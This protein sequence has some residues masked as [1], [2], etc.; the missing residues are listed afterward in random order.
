MAK[1]IKQKTKASI[2]PKSLI[3]VGVASL[4]SA[5]GLGIY[6]AARKKPQEVKSSSMDKSPS[7]DQTQ[8][9]PSSRR[10]QN[11]NR[12]VSQPSAIPVS[13]RPQDSQGSKAQIQPAVF[14]PA[15]TAS[16]TPDTQSQRAP[17][18]LPAGNRTIGSTVFY[19][20]EKNENPGTYTFTENLKGSPL[21]VTFRA[22]PRRGLATN[23]AENAKYIG[24]LMGVSGA[25]KPSDAEVDALAYMILRER[26]AIGRLSS[27]VEAQRE[28]VAML[29]AVVNRVYS[30]KRTIVGVLCRSDMV[31]Y[32]EDFKDPSKCQSHH[33][34][35]PE[36]RAAFKDL[37]RGFFEGN[38][39]CE[40]EGLQNW[41]HPSG[42]KNW[43]SWYLP[44]GTRDA[45][46]SEISKTSTIEP[47]A[48]EDAVFSR[49]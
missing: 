40:T 9:T 34:W 8:K 42:A 47:L 49:A 45:S 24:Q 44:A 36:N 22:A 12:E 4:L 26:N 35:T 33:N 14:E 23:I 2:L 29:W 46:G 28:R 6:L 18:I 43:V 11:Q 5:V 31:S 16:R 15:S 25:Y 17:S 32:Y 3:G 38:F 41:L 19:D 7:T 27:E 30:Y 48:F 10:N 37:V 20:Y 39:N 1:A 13:T 21:T